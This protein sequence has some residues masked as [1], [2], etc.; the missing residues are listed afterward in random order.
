VLESFFELCAGKGKM[1]CEVAHRDDTKLDWDWGVK[2]KALSCHFPCNQTVGA[3]LSGGPV[4]RTLL[5]EWELL[6]SLTTT[7]TKRPECANWVKQ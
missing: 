7:Y 4:P 1:V 2:L 6:A 5:R 3:G